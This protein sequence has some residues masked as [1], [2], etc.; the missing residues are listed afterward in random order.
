M[1]EG[2]GRKVVVVDDESILATLLS[3]RL[4][5]AGFDSCYALNALEAKVLV[6]NFDPDAMVVDLNLGDGP[7]GIELVVS[8]QST[9]PNL[10][11]VI[12]SN[13]TPTPWELKAARKVAFVRKGEVKEFGLLLEALE[14]VLRDSRYDQ[15]RLSSK[16]DSPVSGLTKKQLRILAMISRGLTNAEIALALEVSSGAIE[17]VSKR[18]YS[19]LGLDSQAGKNRRIQAAQLY[20]DHTISGEALWSGNSG[21]AWVAEMRFHRPPC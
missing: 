10:G 15:A 14:S 4:T 8:L 19:R 1:T 18:I 13:F 7:T 21:L 9:Y 12:L 11:F 5:T 20:R 16:L 3:D 2:L 6:E 17:Q